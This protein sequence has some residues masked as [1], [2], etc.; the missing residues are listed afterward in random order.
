MCKIR[1]GWAEARANGCFPAFAGTPAKVALV[2]VFSTTEVDLCLFQEGV[3]Y[4][5]MYT[6]LLRPLCCP[7]SVVLRPLCSQMESFYRET[8]NCQRKTASAQKT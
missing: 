4:S 3:R 8:K 1:D 7:I 6:F 2:S 5:V